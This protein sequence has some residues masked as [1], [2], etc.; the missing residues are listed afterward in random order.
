MKATFLLAFIVFAFFLPG[1]KKSNGS[2]SCTPVNPVVS[3]PATQLAALQEYLATRG[4]IGSA[5]RHSSDFYYKIDNEGSGAAPTTCSNVTVT[6]RGTLTDGT[7]FT[8]AAE[9]ANPNTFSLGGLITGWQLGLQLIKKGGKITLYLPP[10]HGYGSSSSGPIPGNSI[11]IFEISL[12]DV[13]N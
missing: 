7:P 2:S 13:V 8:T 11:L 6:Y 10:S 5:V 3:V 12:L 9:L 1:C 4:L